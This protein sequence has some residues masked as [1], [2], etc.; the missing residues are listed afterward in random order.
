VIAEIGVNHEGSVSKAK[1]LI[2]Q[3]KE[4]G[5]SSVK[6]QAYKAESLVTKKANAYWD[7]SQEKTESQFELFKKYDS[8][9]LKDYVELSSY[10]HSLNMQFGLS[11]F[12]LD[13]IEPLSELVDYFKIASGDLTFLPLLETVALYNKPII[14]S[15]GAATLDEIKRSYA[16]LVSNGNA[17]VSLLHCIL[18]YPANLY[19]SNLSFMATLLKN[20]PKSRVGISDHIADS[21]LDRFMIA[22]AMGMSIVEKHFTDDPTRPGNDHYHSGNSK[23]FSDLIQRIK[24]TDL[25]MGTGEEYLLSELPARLGARRS[26]VY[27][28]DMVAGQIVD[29]NSFLFKRP[30][31]GLEP[32]EFRN[33]VGRELTH[34]V[35]ADELVELSDFV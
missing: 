11:I 25:L 1:T 10:S 20:F 8:F 15:T 6:L 22:R 5:C 28:S 2:Y 16:T 27:K 30:G 19:D 13:W 12:D 14:L 7:R 35:S 21:E 26:I 17:D 4:A 33:L 34:S 24:Y 9:E 18:S 3:A 29:S 23:Y 32:F 31:E